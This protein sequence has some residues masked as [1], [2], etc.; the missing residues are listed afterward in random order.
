MPSKFQGKMISNTELYSQSSKRKRKICVN[1]KDF[2]KFISHT[3]FSRK[4]L[5]DAIP[6]NENI[7]KERNP[8]KWDKKKERGEGDS[9]SGD[10]GKFQDD[11]SAAGLEGNQPQPE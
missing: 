8:K 9:Q 3:S 7:V 1:R 5:K 11:R 6:Q 2:L 10:K 4:L